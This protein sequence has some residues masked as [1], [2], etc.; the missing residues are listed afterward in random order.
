MGEKKERKKSVHAEWGKHTLKRHIQ[1]TW[2][3]WIQQSEHHTVYC[4]LL[5]LCALLLPQPS[6]LLGVF[7]WNNLLNS[8][9]SLSAVTCAPPRWDAWVHPLICHVILIPAR[10]I[11]PTYPTVRQALLPPVLFSL[12][13]H[14]SSPFSSHASSRSCISSLISITSLPNGAFI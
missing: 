5:L 6:F 4:K 10:L 7:M 9:S 13:S 11:F 8:C 2:M 1:F 12:H 14:F 3:K